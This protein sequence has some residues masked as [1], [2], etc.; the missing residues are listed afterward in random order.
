[1]SQLVTQVEASAAMGHFDIHKVSE[2]LVSRC[3]GGAS[4][5]YECAHAQL[6]GY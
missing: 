2:G 1:M 4:H 3:V 5:T 6:K